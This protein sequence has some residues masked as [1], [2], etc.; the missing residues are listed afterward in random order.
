MS[1]KPTVT[2]TFAGD[3]KSLQKSAQKTDQALTTVGTSADRSSKQL[4]AASDSSDR[5][6]TKMGHLGSA[7]T[8][9]GDAID[10][11]SGG[12]QAFTDIS[13]AGADKQA[14][15]SRALNDVEQAQEDY[16][17]ALRDSSQAAIDSGQ[18][19]IDLTQANLDAELALTAYNE[20]VNKHGVTSAEARQASIDLS[21]AQQD[22]AQ[23]N[24]DSAQFTRDAAQATIDAK[25][26]QLDLNEANR[27][28]HPPDMQG[29]TDTLNL[30]MPLISGVIGVVGMATAGQ[31]AWNTSM[32]ASPL[33]WI[34][35]A[36]VALI[37]VIV[38][39]AIKTDWFQKLW[40]AAWGGIKAAATAVWE[41]L[42]KMPDR[43]AS[44]FG[45]IP[46][47]ITWPFRTAFNAVSN[48]W[49]ATIG[50]LSWTVPGWVPGIGGNTIS[51]PRMP[52][53]HTGG[54]VPGMPGQEV[55]AVLR[56]GETVNTSGQGGGGGTVRFVGNVDTAL[57]TLIMEMIR[58]GV[59]QLEPAA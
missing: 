46:S 11:A 58:T 56:G 50:K 48:A 16:N 45:R 47:L 22:I 31:W 39:I 10:M 33:T 15:L 18:A 4:A 32:F 27:E 23:A 5:L 40:A 53:F 43:I 19:A 13:Q 29:W 7:V 14:R 17:Q 24:E 2:L 35:I 41:D 59:I 54:V 30:V 1:S 36:I 34:V 37:A 57:A 25:G 52:T 26:A 9:A 51:A 49:N 20:A 21:Q 6:G 3:E 38:L 44:A 28:A 42:Q 8:G 12:M 55:L